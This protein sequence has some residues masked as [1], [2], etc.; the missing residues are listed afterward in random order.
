VSFL[1]IKASAYLA[2]AFDPLKS[3]PRQTER[4]M[5]RI[6]EEQI[7]TGNQEVK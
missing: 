1:Q 6:D 4:E 2:Q 3:K 5:G 7:Q